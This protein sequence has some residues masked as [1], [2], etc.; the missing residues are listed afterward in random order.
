M[1]PVLI[2]S[3]PERSFQKKNGSLRRRSL[4]TPHCQATLEFRTRG[5]SKYPLQIELDNQLIN[6]HL[7]VFL[8][9]LGQNQF[10]G[11]GVIESAKICLHLQQLARPIHGHIRA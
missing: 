3:S 1:T 5:K 4:F 7:P 9:D 6:D 10:G 2:A 8:L 11:I